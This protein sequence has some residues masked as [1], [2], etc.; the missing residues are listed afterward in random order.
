MNSAEKACV[1][2]VLFIEWL[3]TQFIPEN[4]SLC[5]KSQSDGLIVLSADGHA[6]HITPRVVTYPGAQWIVLIRLVAQSSHINQ[7]WDFCVFSMS[8]ILYKK[9]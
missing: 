9:Q 1:T 6:S 8:K 5:I 7:L 3:Q 2:E 4:G